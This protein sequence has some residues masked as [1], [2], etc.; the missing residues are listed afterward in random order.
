MA[1]MNW[2]AENRRSRMRKWYADNYLNFID[3]EEP[4]QGDDQWDLWAKRQVRRS[5]RRVAETATERARHSETSEGQ[6]LGL[7]ETAEKH[8]E[9]GDEAGA[10]ESL[11]SA[12]SITQQ[13][14]TG[15]LQRATSQA[16]LDC[17]SLMWAMTELKNEDS[18]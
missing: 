12:L 13:S 14:R 18:S 3:L 15:S 11:S 17:V 8:I 10:R 2:D 6:I 5:I 4:P 1:R 16:V 9:R 7:L